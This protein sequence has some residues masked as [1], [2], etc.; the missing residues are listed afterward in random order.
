MLNLVGL[1][2]MAFFAIGWA[3]A[4]ASWF[5]AAYYCIN[6]FFLPMNERTPSH[7][8]K[9]LVAVALFFAGVAFALVNGR[10]GAQWGG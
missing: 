5:F 2:S 4:I 8:R 7:R 3:V 1:I 10:I 9:T 6:G